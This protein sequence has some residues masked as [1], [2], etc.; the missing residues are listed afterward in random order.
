MKIRNIASTVGFAA[1]L[2]LSA[3]A[4]KADTINF[5][6]FTS[7]PVT[8]CFSDTGII[9]PIVYSTVTIQDGAGSGH[10]MNSEGWSN[11][12]TSGDNLFGTLS[13]G[14]I[15]FLFNQDVFGLNF[16]LI[17]GTGAFDFVVSIF[18][19]NDSLLGS[20]TISLNS[21]A[22]QGSV[23]NVAF[24][25]TGIRTVHIAGSDDFAVDTINFSTSGGAVPEPAS[26]ALMI[27][28]FGLA[29]GAL[30]RRRALAA[31]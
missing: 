15:D 1:A 26:W 25:Q 22:T 27:G 4:A 23:Q 3:F 9:G 19:A 7:P 28:G 18:D 21:F 11:Q 24:G 17:N 13:S 10:V 30:R 20:Q 16:D 29:G 12:Q 14:A 5:D 6:E 8:C 31:A 2:T